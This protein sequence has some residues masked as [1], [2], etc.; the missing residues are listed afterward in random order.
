MYTLLLLLLLLF[1]F[2]ILF[3][4]GERASEVSEILLVVVQ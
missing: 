4:I 1:F 3:F 2:I